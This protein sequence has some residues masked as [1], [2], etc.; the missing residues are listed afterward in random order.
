M[1]V[2]GYL[3]L[4][5]L[6]ISKSEKTRWKNAVILEDGE[7]LNEKKTRIRTAFKAEL[8]VKHHETWKF[9]APSELE[10]NLIRYLVNFC[11]RSW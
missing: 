4:L 3:I 6:V 7:V 11:L 8:I 2:T 10:V 9:E 5:S 1:K